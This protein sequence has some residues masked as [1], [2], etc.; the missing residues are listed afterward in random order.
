M[1]PENVSGPDAPRSP[2]GHGRRFELHAFVCVSDS[3]CNIDG[4]AADI[5]KML[6][7]KL[8]ETGMKEQVRIN[9]SGCLGQCGHGPMMVVYPEGVWYSHLTMDDAERIWDEHMVG[10]N[11]VA[12]L[13]FKTNAPGTNVIP[14]ASN[15]DRTPQANSPYYSP[16]TRCPAIS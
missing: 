11:P 15:E 4:Q 13:E 10:G 16:C 14:F 6:K 7:S 9:Q 5:R 8:R 1:G 2:I 3:A 12:D